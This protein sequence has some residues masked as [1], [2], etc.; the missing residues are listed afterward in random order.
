[1]TKQEGQ[2]VIWGSGTRLLQAGMAKQRISE[3]CR[4]LKNLFI[5]TFI[6]F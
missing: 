5:Y 3:E 2:G 4:T 6:C 1:M